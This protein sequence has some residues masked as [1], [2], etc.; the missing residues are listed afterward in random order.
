MVV[1]AGESFFCAYKYRRCGDRELVRCAMSHPRLEDL[2]FNYRLF[3]GKSALIFGESD[4]G[5]S[6]IIKDIMW[7]LNPHIDQVIVVSP[8]DRKNRSYSGGLVPRPLV[9]SKITAKML[10]DT[11]QRQ[12][13]LASVY[14][15]ANRPEVLQRL[16]AHVATSEA[17]RIVMEI[18]RRKTDC[19][20]ELRESGTG[21][22]AAKIKENDTNAREL[23]A[24]IQKHF[25]NCGMDKFRNMKL[26]KDERF[27]LQYLNLNPNLLW[28]FD[29]CT[30]GLAKFKKHP[31]IQELFYQ[32]R[33]SH[34]TL[35][36]AA[37]T[38]KVLDPEI[39]SNSFV[40]IFAQEG[41]ARSYYNRDSTALD[42]SHKALAFAACDEAFTPALKYQKLVHVRSSGKF[43]KFT[44]SVHDGFRFG[45][46]VIWQFCE[47]IE[48]DADDM[49]DNKFLSKFD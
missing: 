28:I 35:L 26:S 3:L 32:G 2:E 23:V 29:D 43:H 5:K 37:H 30:S 33:H 17:Q 25:I 36:I 39:K 18:F 41:V 8:S 21:D 12:E 13:A 1:V 22:I 11:W 46:P 4:S 14:E 48:N 47:M 31:V 24:K 34:V 9:H 16:F 45:S 40:K 49:S 44:A 6:T 27:T 15:R 7:V 42:K 10:E 38:D 20:R 19:E